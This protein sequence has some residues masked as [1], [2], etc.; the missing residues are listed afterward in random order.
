MENS[1]QLGQNGA[2]HL[3][4]TVFVC[5]LFF[6]AAIFARRSG[7]NFPVLTRLSSSPLDWHFPEVGDS[8]TL[9][10]IL[11]LLALILYWKVVRHEDGWYVLH[12]R[13]HAPMAPKSAFIVT[14]LSE[15]P[16]I[17]SAMPKLTLI[18]FTFVARFNIL[19]IFVISLILG[20]PV[21]WM[22]TNVYRAAIPAID[23]A[24]TRQVREEFDSY[25]STTK[26]ALCHPS[27]TH[28]R[29]R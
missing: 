16:H 19:F 15:S 25:S 7:P 28:S 21:W 23:L 10:S 11:D 26:T 1:A 22:T 2:P 14:R 5:R 9:R 29:M 8:R 3:V 12:S 17:P 20:V 24:N 13:S 6:L 18:F 27:S 4:P